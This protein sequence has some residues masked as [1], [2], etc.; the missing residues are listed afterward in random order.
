MDLKKIGY[1]LF[2]FSLAILAGSGIYKLFETVILDS[3]LGI[4]YKVSITGIVIGITVLII[5]LIIE[6]IK[7]E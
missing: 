5:G 2:I 3:T 4:T 1:Y 6:R 7:G